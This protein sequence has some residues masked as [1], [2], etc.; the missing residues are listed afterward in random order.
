M[1]QRNKIQ[2]QKPI[3]LDGENREWNVEL[4]RQL[5]FARHGIGESFKIYYKATV[6]KAV[7]I[8][9]RWVLASK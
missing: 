2:E 7:I 8:K 4:L 3:S 9:R 1:M 6:Y 5:E